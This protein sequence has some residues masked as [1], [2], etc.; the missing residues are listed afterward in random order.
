MFLCGEL[1]MNIQ[2]EEVPHICF[3]LWYA[4]SDNSG[5]HL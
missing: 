1:S 5:D 4:V 3:I 2:Y